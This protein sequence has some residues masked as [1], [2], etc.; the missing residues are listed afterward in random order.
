LEVGDV[1]IKDSA[2][3]LVKHAERL[4]AS[5]AEAYAIF[6]KTS[7]LYIDDNIP[8]VAD[9]KSEMG[10][11]LRFI[12]KRKVGFTSST[13]LSETIQD[14]TARARKM[15]QLSNEDPKFISLPNPKKPSGKRDRFF[16]RNTAEANSEVLLEKSMQL[17]DSSRSD[18][19]TVPNGVLRK[20]SLDFQVAN[21]LGV[22]TG[23]KSTMV[24]GYFTAKAEENGA[25]GEGVQ[26]VWSRSLRDVDFSSK[27]QILQQQALDV[28][29]AK[30]FKE[31]WDDVIAV[32][33]PS[34][35]SEMLGSLLGYTL[36]AEN[37][38]NRSSHWTDR[39][40][41]RVAHESL[42][43]IDNGLSER[44]MLSAI[45]DDEGTPT[46]RTLAI[47]NGILRSYIFDTYNANQI[48]L[49]STGNGMRRR[50]R[51]AHGAFNSSVACRPTTLEV[52][53]GST[54]LDEMIS[55]VKHGVYIE[56]FA[57]PLVD[58]Y[59]GAFSNE[60]RNASLIENGELTGKVKYALLVGN[61]YESLMKG[62]MI[63]SDLEV[64]NCCVMPT[65]AFAGT[66]I[67]GQ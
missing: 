14:V 23:S 17:V 15:A 60:I 32:L 28:I 20:S 64:N 44:G 34:E 19:V 10:V 13:L 56:H 57:F 61:M 38:N 50:Y 33:A 51:D 54:S 62:L 22:D 58:P 31:K 30:A 27:G 39:V 46:H 12:I 40:G 6:A 52:P 9:T 47:E 35:C 59:S 11:G 8:K 25:V 67:V 36:S 1:D 37:V 2:E 24:F 63:G 7:S 18:T 53:A 48:K 55:E 3:L 65:I 16:D 4:G 26:R 29:H 49:Q 45:V 42:T 5:E 21:S 43:V 66:E 41:D